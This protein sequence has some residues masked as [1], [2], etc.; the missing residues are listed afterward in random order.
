VPPSHSKVCGDVDHISSTTKPEKCHKS[1]RASLRNL[2][3][4]EISIFPREIS[5]FS[6]EKIKISLKNKVPKLALKGVNHQM[7][8]RTIV[9]L[10]RPSTQRW[11]MD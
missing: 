2:F 5:S 11:W 7:F 9:V 3:A 6:L 8:P 1:F 4:Q 10:H